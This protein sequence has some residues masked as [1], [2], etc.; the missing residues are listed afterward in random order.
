MLVSDLQFAQR[1]PFTASAKKILSENNFSLEELPEE[2]LERAGAMVLSAAKN[3]PYFLKEI[4]SSSAL[5][6][7]EI[8]AFPV[9]KIL[10][11][12]QKSAF[13]NEKF[14]LMFS[15][16]FLDYIGLEK[17]PQETLL[18]IASQL[19]IEFEVLKSRDFF[20]SVS[21]ESFLKI[22][23]KHPA[24]KL[25]NQSVSRG[26]VFLQEHLFFVF[27]SEMVFAHIFSSLPVPLE[28]IP[29]NLKD[30]A[31]QLQQQLVVSQKKDFEFRL[32]GKINP[33]FF[34]SCMQKM[35]NDL[36]EGKN[37]PHNARFYIAA[38]LNSIGMPSEQIIQ[39]FSKTP[40]FSEK[41]TRYQVERVVKQG[42][43]APSCSKIKEA[44]L[45]PD[46]ECGNKHPTGFYERQFLKHK[47]AE[48]KSIQQK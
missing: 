4:S 40:N 2:V 31:R 38:F 19:G 17:H 35:Y 13:L 23:F 32:S 30:F 25:V 47:K 43:S 5:L 39:L 45:C 12:L 24:L 18:E 3:K 22:H 15:K 34:P 20:A 21:L 11:S 7:Q 42:L 26:K 33:N 6:L 10:V 14:A 41:M 48:A 9:A 27:V 46:A 8:L 29:K 44:G 28:G 1:F 16:S 37:L 36:L